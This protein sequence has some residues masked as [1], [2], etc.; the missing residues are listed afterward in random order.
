MEIDFATV[1]MVG[2]AVTAVLGCIYTYQK[3][4]RNFEEKKREDKAEILQNA[5]EELSLLKIDLELKIN[6]VSVA[7]KAHQVFVEK[8]MSH[9]RETYN[10]ELKNLGEKIED[11]RSDLKDQHSQLVSLLTKMIDNK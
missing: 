6:T 8:D 7:L 2:T 5:K 10:G 4:S 9:M 11:L 1:E 3:I